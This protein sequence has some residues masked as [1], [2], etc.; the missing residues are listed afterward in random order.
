MLICLAQML[1]CWR[2]GNKWMFNYVYYTELTYSHFWEFHTNTDTRLGIKK[3]MK[4]ILCIISILNYILS[5]K[6]I[7]GY[8]CSV[9]SLVNV[10]YT[11]VLSVIQLCR[12][13]CIICLCIETSSRSL[14]Q[15][16]CSLI[17]FSNT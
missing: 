3:L 13:F 17:H 12:G 14:K 10:C 2:T 1:C 6:N 9:P 7:L 16:G 11:S 8:T 5:K 15:H 4:W